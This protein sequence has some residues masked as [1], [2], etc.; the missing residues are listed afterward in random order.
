MAEYFTVPQ[1]IGYIAAIIM[2]LSLQMRTQ[3]GFVI[4]QLISAACWVVH[5]GLLS[6][7][8]GM[9]LNI[10]GV[11]RCVVFAQ[12]DEKKWARSVAWYPIFISLYAVA[13]L[14]AVFV[15]S[16]GWRAWLPFFG[17]IITTF[18]MTRTDPFKIRLLCIAN[19]PFWLSYNLLAASVSGVLVETF[20][21]ISAIVGIIRLDVPK[22]RA[23]RQLRTDTKPNTDSETESGSNG[24]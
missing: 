13:T 6:A 2:V 9:L 18:A 8:S 24:N 14:L 12:R 21:F 15:F 23:A 7:F 20:N 5:L 17:M 10:I 19:V 16:D 11:A 4:L 22:L 3:K 1:L